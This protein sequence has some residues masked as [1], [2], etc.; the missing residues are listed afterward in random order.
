MKPLIYRLESIL[1]AFFFSLLRWMP[2]PVAS[3]FGAMLAQAIGPLFKA[4]RTA[5][6]NL[7]AAFP[8]KDSEEI[9]RITRKMW[10]HLGR[11]GAEYPFLAK[12]DLE[13]YITV[14]GAG[15][16]P[17]P[18]EKALFFSGHI[19]N[20][21]LLPGVAQRRGTDISLVYRPT[22]NPY[23]D[24][25]MATLR[26]PHCNQLIAKGMRGGVHIINAIKRGGTVALLADQKQNN[27]IAVP[28]FGRDAM[29]SPAIAEIALKY[30]LPIIP[31]QVIRTHGAHFKVVIYPPIRGQKTDDHKQ[32]VLNLMTQI[33]TMLEE[34]VQKYPEQWFWVHRRWP[35]SRI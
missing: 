10:R 16:L 14:I 11:V 35:D 25:M 27:G 28:F 21:E 20:W 19:G 31:A 8:D 7:A 9:N 32:D 6:K 12:A 33:N 13:K 29:T 18:P 2:M 23:I 34:W 17:K 1:L 22:N 30:D 3:G 5:K 26:Q 4:N 15:H 24:R